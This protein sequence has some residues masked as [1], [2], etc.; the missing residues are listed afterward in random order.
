MIYT[1]IENNYT[2][3]IKQDARKLG[4]KLTSVSSNDVCIYLTSNERGGIDAVFE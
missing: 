1:V 3:K 4:F 2:E